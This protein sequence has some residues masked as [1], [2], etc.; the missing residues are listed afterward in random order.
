MF[1]VVKPTVAL[2]V[3]LT[4]TSVVTAQGSRPARG[5]ETRILIAYHS[6]TGSTEQMARAVASGAKTVAGSMITV[7]RVEQVV[8]ADLLNA[9][10]IILGSP[11]YWANMA[12]TMKQFIDD[13]AFKYQVYLGNKVGGAFATSGNPTGGKEHVIMSLLLAMLNNGMIVAGPVFEENGIRYGNFGAGA[14]TGSA[15][16][17]ALSKSGLQEAQRLGR[18]IATIAQKMKRAG[19][20]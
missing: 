1:K 18:R 16:N 10:A 4:M 14:S 12:G 6:L 3:L 9:D 19:N 13:W 8:R 2:L 15:E 11:T 5:Q 7:K 20:R 17:P